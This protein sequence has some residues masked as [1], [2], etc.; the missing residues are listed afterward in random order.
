LL[1]HIIRH[2]GEPFLENLVGRIAHDHALDGFLFDDTPPTRTIGVEEVFRQVFVHGDED[3]SL[4]HVSLALVARFP[5]PNTSMGSLGVTL[6]HAWKYH[7]VLVLL[8]EE[9]DGDGWVDPMLGTQS[10]AHVW[11]PLLERKVSMGDRVSLASE[12]S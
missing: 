10:N 4:L 9:A 3:D 7:F 11:T 6:Q 2:E 5:I 1:P 12:L 8:T